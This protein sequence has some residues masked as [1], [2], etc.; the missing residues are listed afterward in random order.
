MDQPKYP[1]NRS[2][3]VCI[4]AS[5]VSFW[6]KVKALIIYG[7]GKINFLYR[8]KDE[9]K[10]FGY[11]RTYL[12]LIFNDVLE[13]VCVRFKA[14]LWWDAQPCQPSKNM[15]ELFKIKWVP[16]VYGVLSMVQC[17]LSA[18]QGKTRKH[19]TAVIKKSWLSVSMHYDPRWTDVKFAWAIH[20]AY[21]R[22]EHVE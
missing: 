9:V 21:R 13:H 19:T 8:Y 10:I 1:N 14:F 20:G 16:K 12:S 5:H 4:L 18:D 7:M 3:S 17:D 15:Q 6:C 2:C 22:L 11:S